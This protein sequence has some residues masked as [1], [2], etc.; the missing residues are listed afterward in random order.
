M[1]IE[2]ASRWRGPDEDFPLRSEGV[3]PGA[4]E[5]F[6]RFVRDGPRLHAGDD[7][8]HGRDRQGAAGQ[9]R[10]R[11]ARLA[12]HGSCDPGFAWRFGKASK[13]GRARQGG[14]QKV[15]R[16]EGDRGDIQK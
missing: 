13:V 8:V 1:A 9:R 10:M 4:T 15:L 14:R 6:G 2:I 12:V 3:D 7:A 5:R 11:G 16:H